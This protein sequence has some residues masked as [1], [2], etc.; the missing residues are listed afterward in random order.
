ML[1]RSE[2]TSKLWFQRDIITRNWHYFCPLVPSNGFVLRSGNNLVGVVPC[3]C[4]GKLPEVRVNAGW[5]DE[6][7]ECTWCRLELLMVYDPF[8]GD[9]TP[10]GMSYLKMETGLLLMVFYCWWW[11]D[12]FSDGCVGIMVMMVVMM[13][14]VMMVM[15]MVIVVMVVMPHYITP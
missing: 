1:W 4:P 10:P 9:L 5:P 6:P 11:R 2:I 8:G 3:M 14:V 13:I 12:G 15:M 7:Y